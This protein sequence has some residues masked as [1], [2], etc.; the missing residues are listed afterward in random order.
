MI[1]IFANKI[2]CDRNVSED[3]GRDY[4][5][6]KDVLYF[7]VSA[8]TGDGIEDAMEAICLALPTEPSFLVTQSQCKFP[9]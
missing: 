6:K 8:K 9:L 3:E 7:E 1:A 2:D 5:M 4:A